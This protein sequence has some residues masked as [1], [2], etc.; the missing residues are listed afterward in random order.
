MEKCRRMKEA[1]KTDEE[2]LMFLDSMNNPYDWTL[3]FNRKT[4]ETLEKK[5]IIQ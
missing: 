5:K 3:I 2:L 1:K 4:K